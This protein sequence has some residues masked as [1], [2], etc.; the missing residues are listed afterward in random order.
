MI[1]SAFSRQ[2]KEIQED[3]RGVV[4]SSVYPGI[5]ELV[6]EIYPEEAHFIYELLQ[7]AEDAQA[8]SVFFEIKKDMLVFRHNGKK[9]FDEDDVD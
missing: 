3:R 1:S 7:N 2:F 6:S 4:N 9:L 5:K 8:S